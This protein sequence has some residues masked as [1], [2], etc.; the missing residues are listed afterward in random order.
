MEVLLS[1]L[2]IENEDN[3]ILLLKVIIDLHRTYSRYSGAPPQKE[4]EK[5]DK[6]WITP[7]AR[8][9]DDLL[10]IVAEFFKG[11]PPVVE[12]LFSGQSEMT[13]RSADVG[14]SQSPAPTSIGME[15]DAAAQ[16]MLAPASKSFKLLQDCPAAIVFIFQTY[17]YLAEKAVNWFVPLVFDV[18]PPPSHASEVD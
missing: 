12:D 16:V 18:S 10:E 7:M 4:N 2:R 11:M 6:Q 13:T 8:S 5:P 14:T 9:A 3:A 17:T 15:V 1:L